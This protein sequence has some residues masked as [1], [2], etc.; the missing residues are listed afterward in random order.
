MP[1]LTYG[2]ER[3]VNTHQAGFLSFLDLA[4]QNLSSGNRT[5]PLYGR[6]IKGSKITPYLNGCPVEG[7][8]SRRAHEEVGKINYDQLIMGLICHYKGLRLSYR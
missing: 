1:S 4:R 6:R 7:L 5:G 2:R 3:A 8:R